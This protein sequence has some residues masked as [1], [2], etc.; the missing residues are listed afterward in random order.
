MD[1]A[2]SAV[3]GL[4]ATIF[5]QPGPSAS[6]PG[7]PAAGL[8]L[9]WALLGGAFGALLGSFVGLSAQG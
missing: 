9:G 6:Q 4:V 3:F 7:L 8:L 2:A 1:L 5:W